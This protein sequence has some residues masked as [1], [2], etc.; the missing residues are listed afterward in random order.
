MPESGFLDHPLRDLEDCRQLLDVIEGALAPTPGGERT[1]Q[2]QHLIATGFTEVAALMLARLCQLRQASQAGNEL[3]TLGIKFISLQADYH[4]RLIQYQLVGLLWYVLC[5]D[6]LRKPTGPALVESSADKRVI[7]AGRLSETANPWNC[8]SGKI[9][10]SLSDAY[11]KA[12]EV[13]LEGLERRHAEA[14]TK[15]AGAIAGLQRVARWD[16]VTTVY[17]WRAVATARH[18][19]R[20]ILSVMDGNN[21]SRAPA[22][23]HNA[24]GPAQALDTILTA[25]QAIPGLLVAMQPLC[26]ASGDDYDQVALA[27]SKIKKQWRFSE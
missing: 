26:E 17:L 20:E 23:L 14:R 6:L 13:V 9:D 3:G 10:D 7:F 24:R 16:D 12:A 2:L 11:Q 18:H 8:L 1:S 21:T 27:L 19:V 15:F 4:V 22:I 25:T 5:S